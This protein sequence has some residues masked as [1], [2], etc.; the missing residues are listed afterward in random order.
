[1]TI[2]ETAVLIT[3]IRALW[4]T[5]Y[6]KTPDADL[7]I[8]VRA[9]QDNFEDKPYKLVNSAL[10][11][12]VRE[13]GSEFPPSASQIYKLACQIEDEQLTRRYYA[14]LDC[15]KTVSASQ[16]GIIDLPDAQDS[17]EIESEFDDAKY[18]E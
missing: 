6:A 17:S 11:R 13:S 16:N 9:W 15:V 7:E 4:P 12:Y 10:K 18:D 5:A 8:I 1:M 14:A 2:Q 3:Y